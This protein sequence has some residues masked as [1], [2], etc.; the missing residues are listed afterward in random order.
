MTRLSLLLPALLL[1]AAPLA[2]QPAAPI[3]KRVDR[4]ESE[5]R[6][7]QRKV[8]PGANPRFFD[9]EVS[10][11]PAP[12]PAAPPAGVPA[13]A[14]L[15]DLTQRVD[16]LERQL[17]TLTGQTEQNGFRIRQL[18]EQ[19]AKFRSD[20]EFRLTQLEGGGAAPAAG[21]PAGTAP[22]AGATPAA[23]ARPAAAGVAAQAAT[24]AAKPADPV[25]A[26]FQAAYLL[27]SNGK[28]AEAADALS[29]FVAKNPKAARA[30]HAQY[31]LG[32]TYLAQKQPA[33]AAKAFLDNYRNMPKGARAPES[34]YWLGQSLMQLSP[35]NAGEA[36]KVY[37]ELES[38]YGKQLTPTLKGLLP[39]ARTAAKC[40]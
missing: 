13:T 35:P 16:A 12:A 18:E 11:A 36:C 4:L 23:G 19:L 26:Q 15:A 9:P 39:R 3:E 28:L 6:A 40:A 2:A 5:M 24:P 21:A 29:A 37:D 38:V 8:F 10:T 32:R 25:E 31:W 1:S 34:L 22:T 17:Q 14:P 7:V 30:S 20:A 27:Y 33:Q